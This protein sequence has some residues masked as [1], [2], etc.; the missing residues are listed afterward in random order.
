MDFLSVCFLQTDV[1]NVTSSYVTTVRGVI[2]AGTAGIIK[3]TTA[4]DSPSRPLRLN[5][6]ATTAAVTSSGSSASRL[7]VLISGLYPRSGHDKHPVTSKAAL[8]APLS[9]PPV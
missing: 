7:A 1:T 8:S 9:P 5:T 2:I 4:A 3:Q 6:A